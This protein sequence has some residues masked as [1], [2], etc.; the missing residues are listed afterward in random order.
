MG[1]NGWNK[2]KDQTHAKGAFLRD[3]IV[4]VVLCVFVRCMRTPY[5]HIVSKASSCVVVYNAI[6]YKSDMNKERSAAESTWYH[7]ST[8]RMTQ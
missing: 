5:V 7:R 8:P 4:F 6:Q 1:W 2:N 3:G